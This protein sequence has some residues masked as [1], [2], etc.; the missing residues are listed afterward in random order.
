MNPPD[1][2]SFRVADGAD[3]NYVLFYVVDTV[4]TP[5]GIAV[6]VND[7]KPLF[8]D[9]V[10]ETTARRLPD[11]GFSAVAW[12]GPEAPG[13]AVAHCYGDA[14]ST[15]EN[16]AC[17]IWSLKALGGWDES[18]LMTFYI[19]H[20]DAIDRD[21]RTVKVR[22]H[23]ATW[24]SVRGERRSGTWVV[25]AGRLR[26]GAWNTLLDDVSRAGHVSTSAVILADVDW[27]MAYNDAY[28][29]QEGDLMLARVHAFIESA[30]L[31]AGAS[32]IRV[33][34]DEYTAIVEGPISNG[35]GLAETI[36]RGVEAMNIPFQHS[37][38]RTHGR[39]TV[40]IGVVPAGGG[41]DLRKLLEDAVYE[42][43]RSGRNRVS[44][45]V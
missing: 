31:R 38:V 22:A 28:G 15:V 27:A 37:E 10:Q 5:S 45:S 29:H 18:D 8:H 9:E 35:A 20:V 25:D 34:G 16:A 6:L 40:S 43:K 1:G 30:S 2:E 11:A 44:V 19:T 26:P 24:V 13:A 42:A 41:M 4:D 39:V 36:R 32:F 12:I 17:G 23:M 14:E 3:K 7:P 33:A 21:Q